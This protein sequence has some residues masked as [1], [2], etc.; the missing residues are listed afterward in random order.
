PTLEDALD[1]VQVRFVLNLP[2][3]ELSS[4]DRLFFQVRR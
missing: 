3:A 1:D 2:E 4:A